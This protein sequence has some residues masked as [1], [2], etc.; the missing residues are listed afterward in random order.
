MYREFFSAMTSHALPLAAMA[1]FV[2][3]FALVLAR[4]FVLRRRADYDSVAAL[5]L[6]DSDSSDSHEVRP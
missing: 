4:V 5:P 3:A 2:V 6:D 1:F